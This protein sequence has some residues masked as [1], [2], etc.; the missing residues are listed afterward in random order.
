MA[1]FCIHEDEQRVR[2]LGT[3]AHNVLQGSDVFEG[4]KG[5]HPI[6]VVT[7]QQQDGGVLD[8]VAFG[9]ADVMER[10]IPGRE[11]EKK[12]LGRSHL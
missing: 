4:V 2:L 11:K 3:A 5:H 9:D 12:K 8:P 7:R 1:R 10:G 6:I